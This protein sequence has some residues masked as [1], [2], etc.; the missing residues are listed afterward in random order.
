MKKIRLGKTG[1]MVSKP[2][3]GCL[4]LQRCSMDEAITI[5]RHAYEGGIN[6][7]DTANAYTDSEEKI[8]QALSDVRHDIIIA[9][10]SQGRD[11]TTVTRHIENSLR[12]LKTDYIDLFQF[13]LAQQ[14]DDPNDANGAY[15]AVLELQ[16]KGYIRHIG[17]TTH[18]LELAFELVKSGLY[19]T[20][21]YPFS[22]LATERELELEQQCRN[23]DL[24]FIAMK[25]LAGGLL[26]NARACHAFMEQFDS[27]APIWGVQSEAE[28]EQWLTLAEEQPALDS[29][30]QAV[31]AA[32]RKMLQGNFCRSCGYCLPCPAG[33]EINQAARMNMLLRRSPWQP[34]MSEQWKNKM[35]QI[36]NCTACGSCAARCPYGL[37]TPELLKY[38]LQDYREFYA[39]HV[40]STLN[41]I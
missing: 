6:F 11:R 30:L 24:G 13:H 16:R 26:N 33:I 31:I 17:V 25:G 29:E 14:V 4:P 40:D 9:T 36:E 22:Y 8:G 21:Q 39:S 15:A 3:L 12:M 1:L 38:M 18:K 37:N 41:K 27:V 7:Y 19:E 35:E 2:A 5:L 34:Y 23:Y 32:D 20:M 10:K 28:L